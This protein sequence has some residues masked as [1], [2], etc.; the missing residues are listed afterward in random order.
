ML[1][2]S[3]IVEWKLQLTIVIVTLL[4]RNDS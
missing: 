4:G 3:Y 1:H 2:D